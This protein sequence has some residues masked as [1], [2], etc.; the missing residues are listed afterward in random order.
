MGFRAA[1]WGGQGLGKGEGILPHQW[2][3]Q[4][5]YNCKDFVTL[6][7]CSRARRMPALTA[8]SN[9]ETSLAWCCHTY[10][11]RTEIRCGSFGP[12]PPEEKSHRL[13]GGE[14][15]FL[16]RSLGLE[17]GGR[18]YLLAVKSRPRVSVLYIYA[19][20]AHRPP[21]RPRRASHPCPPAGVD[22]RSDVPRVSLL[23]WAPWRL[24]GAHPGYA[25]GKPS[26]TPRITTRVFYSAGRGTG[27]SLRGLRGT[28]ILQSRVP[29]AKTRC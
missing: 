1:S 4:V 10:T 18:W 11:P 16:L 15:H 27:P 25:S 14:K 3:T 20:P 29:D 24:A 2:E 12:S 21:S 6:S 13:L 8:L 19:Y 17:S 23:T 22:F 26:E 7:K 28:H 9:T 5:C